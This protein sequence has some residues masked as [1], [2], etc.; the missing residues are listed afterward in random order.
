MRKLFPILC[1]ASVAA[2]CGSQPQNAFEPTTAPAIEL[3][4]ARFLGHAPT[5]YTRE[6]FCGQQEVAAWS[7]PAGQA[8]FMLLVARTGCGVILPL[9]NEDEMIKMWPWLSEGHLTFGGDPVMI[10]AP[11][12]TI[13]VRQF[14]RNDQHCFFLRHG[15][16]EQSIDT[17]L[18]FAEIHRRLF[19]R[20]VRRSEH[21]IGYRGFRPRPPG[22]L[23]LHSCAHLRIVRF[24]FIN[25]KG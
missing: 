17:R 19:L 7:V 24:A 12:G 9:E 5:A 3:R 22:P 21:E 13:W 23:A 18:D 25:A 6:V 16:G 4:D 8:G 20:P 10:E 1:I 15:F 14:E 11:L 2:G